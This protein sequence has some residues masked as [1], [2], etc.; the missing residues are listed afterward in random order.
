MVLC[1]LRVWRNIISANDA[2][3]KS[4]LAHHRSRPIFLHPRNIPRLAQLL[5]HS[6]HKRRISCCKTLLALS[7]WNRL[8]IRLWRRCRLDVD[9]LMYS[10]APYGS[11]TSDTLASNVQPVKESYYMKLLNRSTSMAIPVKSTTSAKLESCSLI[12]SGN[13]GAIARGPIACMKVTA[14]AQAKVKNF[15]KGLQFYPPPIVRRSVST[16]LE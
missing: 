11:E 8:S 4:L 7:R 3:L 14:D 6:V 12:N 9:Q 15:Q 10:E 1:V 2:R 16:R 5:F 13:I